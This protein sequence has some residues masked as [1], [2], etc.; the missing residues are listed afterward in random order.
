MLSSL[1]NKQVYTFESVSENYELL[2]KT[3][4][5]ND[6]KNIVPEKIALGAEKKEIEINIAGS[7]SSIVT[8]SALKVDGRE[9]V[10]MTSLDLYMKEHPFI[11][12]GLI[13]VDIEGFEQEFLK[14][15]WRKEIKNDKSTI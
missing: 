5:L 8:S 13:K 6:L 11:N 2:L 3:I 12:P 4:A 7:C 15:Y 9:K 1:T 10:M 14:R